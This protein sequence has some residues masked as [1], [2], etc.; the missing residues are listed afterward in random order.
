MA[1]LAGEVMSVCV[2][3]YV[4][5]CVCVYL[6]MCVFVCQ[7]VCVCDITYVALKIKITEYGIPGL[8]SYLSQ[9]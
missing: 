4:F 9:G 2:Y 8:V 6:C 1:S 3:V 5:F 7:C